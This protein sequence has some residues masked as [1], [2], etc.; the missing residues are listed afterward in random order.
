L[1]V[2][3]GVIAARTRYENRRRWIDSAVMSGAL[4]LYATPL[5][6][7]SLM[8]IILFSVVLGWLPAFGMETIGAGYTGMARVKDVALHMILP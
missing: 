7:L 2:L 5:F 1:G 4:L 8:A 6:W 3:L